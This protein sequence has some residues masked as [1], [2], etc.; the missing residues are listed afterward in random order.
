MIGVYI[1]FLAWWHLANL[2]DVCS[3]NDSSL[4]AVPTY[5]S[6]WSPGSG[7][8]LGPLCS[9]YI[10]SR[11]DRSILY[12]RQCTSTSFNCMLHCNLGILGGT[13]IDQSVAE[14]NTILEFSQ[15]CPHPSDQEGCINSPTMCMNPFLL[16]SLQNHFAMWMV[17]LVK[18]K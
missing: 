11:R 12:L 18:L 4:V 10:Q 14:V 3:V 15:P 5:T 7:R 8:L 17:I 13:V 9:V 1:N 2:G 16:L 6:L